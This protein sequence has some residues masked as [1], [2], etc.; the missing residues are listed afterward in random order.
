MV[1]LRAFHL[2]LMKVEQMALMKDLDSAWKMD[3]EKELY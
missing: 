3:S 2:V 1:L